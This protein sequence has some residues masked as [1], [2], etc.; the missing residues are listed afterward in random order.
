MLLSLITLEFYST[1]LTKMDKLL[2]SKFIKSI[3]EAKKAARF[4]KDLQAR[5]RG[6]IR[7]VVVDVADPLKMGRVK[8]VVDSKDGGE[9]AYASEWIPVAE[10][11][12]GTQ[13]ET[14]IGTRVDLTATDSDFQKLI[15]SNIIRDEE[16]KEAPK[17]TTMVRLPAYP[18]GSLPPATKENLGCMIVVESKAYDWDFICVCLGKGGSYYWVPLSHHN[19]EHKG[20]LVEGEPH[21]ADFA[22][23][24]VYPTTDK[25]RPLNLTTKW[26]ANE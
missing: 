20:L 10:P 6:N 24:Q 22:F 2:S 15:V 16:S 7:G 9:V 14:L 8:V 12:S 23:D 19:H 26:L 5:T 17:N 4:A 3:L 21:E 25:E 1:I 11:F 13:P 18:K